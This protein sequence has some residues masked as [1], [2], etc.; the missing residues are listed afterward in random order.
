MSEWLC[1]KSTDRTKTMKIAIIDYEFTDDDEQEGSVN[2]PVCGK[3]WLT[4]EDGEAFAD[5]TPECPHLRFVIEPEADKIDC[6]N[7]F[8]VGDLAASLEPMMESLKG[9]DSADELSV[10]DFVIENRS[11]QD[12]WTT[13]ECA[14]VDTVLELTQQGMACGP[15]WMTVHFGAKL[16]ATPG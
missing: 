5:K 7:G 8:Q 2:C 16:D 6:F 15:V 14:S 1:D 13:A 10:E 3:P 4:V 12:L 11:D 9:A